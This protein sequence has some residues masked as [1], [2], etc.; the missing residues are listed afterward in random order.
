M[1]PEP[2]DQYRYLSELRVRKIAER[3]SLKKLGRRRTNRQ[4]AR[5]RQ[6]NEIEIP[7]IVQKLS[8]LQREMANL[9]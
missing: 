7:A 2:S 5:L 1:L 8:Q 6:L 4:D 9:S 3:E